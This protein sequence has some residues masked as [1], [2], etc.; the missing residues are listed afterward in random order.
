[1]PAT[2]LVP[3]ANLDREEWLKWRRRGIGSSDAAAVA[4]LSPWKSPMAVWLEKTSQVPDEPET[5]AMYWGKRLEDLVAEEFTRRTGL[6]TRRRK[7]I[8]QHREHPFMIAD[9]D[10]VV[11]GTGYPV[12]CKTTSQYMQDAWEADKIPD[13]YMIQLQHQMAVVGAEKGFFAVLIG[14]REFRWFQIERDEE[15]IGYL[16]EIERRFWELV[17]AR[18][19]PEP[20]GSE[21]ATEMLKHLYPEARPD[22][23]TILPEEAKQFLADYDE[24]RAVVEKWQ[25]RMD[26]AANRLKAL[27]GDHE[28]GLLGDRRVIWKSVSSRRFDTKRF[29]SDCPDLYEEYVT[30]SAYRRFSVK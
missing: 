8:L 18:T 15:L 11:V 10:R 3:T 20:D 30:Q 6:R 2:V 27:L 9:L 1:M 19:P 29:R 16:I 23:R 7:A 25:R 24:A 22:S 13:H 12:E 26:E 21:A 4:G 17:E 28:V 14:G 5:E